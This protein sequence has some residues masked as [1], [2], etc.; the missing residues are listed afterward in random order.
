MFHRKNNLLKVNSSLIF[1]W[2]SCS[3]CKV[4]NIKI[5]CNHSKR[6]HET[7][8]RR[9][10]NVL[11]VLC[12]QSMS[13]GVKKGSNNLNKKLKNRLLMFLTP[14][15]GSNSHDALHMLIN[16]KRET[17]STCSTREKMTKFKIMKCS[18]K[19]SLGLTH[20]IA[21]N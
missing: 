4:N 11:W 14:I 19:E 5:E 12:K 8:Y 7:N 18:S 1:I 20:K 13:N 17:W 3:R 10:S 2:V 16:C 6:L 15:I 21:L 9:Y